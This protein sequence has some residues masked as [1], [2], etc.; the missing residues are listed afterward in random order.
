MIFDKLNGQ[1][2]KKDLFLLCNK[3]RKFLSEQL[4]KE[5]FRGFSVH[6]KN[7]VNGWSIDQCGLRIVKSYKGEGYFCLEIFGTF[8]DGSGYEMKNIL[9]QETKDKLKEYLARDEMAD[10]M[11]ETFGNFSESIEDKL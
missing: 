2:T 5:D 6:F 7:I 9:L 4:E 11:I 8:P 1:K 3:C 10:E